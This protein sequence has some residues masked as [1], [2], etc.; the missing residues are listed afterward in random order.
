MLSEDGKKLTKI[1]KENKKE[2]IKIYDL[3]GNET[4]QTIEVN[5]ISD[6]KEEDKTP[7]KEDGTNPPKEDGTTPPKED[8]NNTTPPKEDGT[9][10]PSDKP[11]EDNTISKDKIPNAGRKILSITAIVSVIILAIVFAIKNRSYKDI[12]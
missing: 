2:Q 5:D 3:A 1:Y 8:G 6:G 4:I 7:P 11:Y 10:S 9:T 12:K